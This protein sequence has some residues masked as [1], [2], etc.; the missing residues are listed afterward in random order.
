[1]EKTVEETGRKDLMFYRPE[2]LTIEESADGVLYDERATLPLNPSFVK[3]IK[4]RGVMVP[5]IV[6]RNGPRIEVIDGRQRVRAAV[7]ANKSLEAE[8]QEPITVPATFKKSSDM[9]ELA[10]TIII[11]NEQR[12]E[13]SVLIKA[14]KASRL[15]ETRGRTDDQVADAFGV[16]VTTVRNWLA[17]LDCS[18]HV[19]GLVESGRIRVT[20]A[21]DIAKMPVEE[22]KA[23]ADKLMAEAPTRKERT[24][25]GEVKKRVANPASRFRKVEKFWKAAE[26]RGSLFSSQKAATA[27]LKWVLGEMSATA[28]GEEFPDLAAMVKTAG[29]GRP[30]KVKE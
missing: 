22:Q 12:A 11:A 18:P 17:M 26:N 8:G 1:M 15:I 27:V 13:D 3:S 14:K 30:K 9:G 6:R 23:A 21:K 10:E 28:L 5:I 29:K 16:T 4:T 20:D 25:K 24:E 2:D 7:V 19:Q